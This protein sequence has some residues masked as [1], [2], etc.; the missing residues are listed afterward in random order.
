MQDTELLSSVDIAGRL[1]G[2]GSHFDSLV[3]EHGSVNI[4]TARVVSSL[5]MEDK[6]HA[7]RM[8]NIITETGGSHHWTI[9]LEVFAKHSPEL[10]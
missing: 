2:A 8:L 5:P 10:T 6:R 7:M 9:D 3:P 4:I 1:D